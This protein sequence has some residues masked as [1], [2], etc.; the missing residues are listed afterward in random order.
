MGEAS[1]VLCE[2]TLLTHFARDVVFV[3]YYRP[4]KIVAYSSSS[5][6]TPG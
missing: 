3:S 5:F 4:F 2:E 1:N 6:F